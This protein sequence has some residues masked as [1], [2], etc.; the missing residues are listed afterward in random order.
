VWVLFSV[1][2]K[3]TTTERSIADRICFMTEVREDTVQH[4]NPP[5]I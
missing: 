1:E 2:A 3:P 5:V 4:D